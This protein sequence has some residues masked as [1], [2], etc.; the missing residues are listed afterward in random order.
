MESSTTAQVA[1]FVF[2]HWN[3]VGHSLTSKQWWSSLKLSWTKGLLSSILSPLLSPLPSMFSKSLH[4]LLHEMGQ[5]LAED[6]NEFGQ[7]GP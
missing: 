6:G 3:V 1:H 4:F 5:A 2:T 7:V